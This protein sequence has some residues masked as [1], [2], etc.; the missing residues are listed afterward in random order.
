ME[1]PNE[2]KEIIIGIKYNM[3]K[4]TKDSLELTKKI[5]KEIN[6]QTF[7][8]HFHIL[9]DI[10]NSYPNDYKIT[11]VEIGCYA[12]GSACLLLQRPLTDVYSIDLGY[13][14]YPEVVLKNV[15]N[16]NKSNNKF[17][18]IQGNSQSTETLNKLRNI[19]DGGIDILFID[20]DHSYE[21]VIN[22]FTLYFPLLEEGGYVIFDDYADYKFSPQV[23]HAVDYVVKNFNG[24]E[25]IG[26][27]GNEFGARGECPSL[28]NEP[29][30]RD[31]NEFVIRKV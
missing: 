16:L 11:Y 8:H 19:I 27:F 28:G 30:K 18:Y 6:E 7:H 25:V 10:A 1:L 24:F 4:T 15:Q 12:G 14:I 5:S 31:A 2:Y 26:C 22:D 20:G 23:K 9:Y 3:L 13:P 21:G 17:T 29:Y